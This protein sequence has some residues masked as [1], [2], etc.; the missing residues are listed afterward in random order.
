MC[1]IT[2]VVPLA[3]IMPNSRFT[4]GMV[5]LDYLIAEDVDV[6]HTADFV[7]ELYQKVTSLGLSPAVTCQRKISMSL[8]PLGKR[9]WDAS[10]HV[11]LS[12]V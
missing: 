5:E 4:R 10:F 7:W 9:F 11:L 12:S 2:A 1:V 6:D 8:R 3:A